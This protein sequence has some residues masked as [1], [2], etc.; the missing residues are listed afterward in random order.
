MVDIE[1]AKKEFLKYTEKFDLKNEHIKGKQQHSLRVMQVSK[2]I[3]ERLNLNKEDVELATLIGL[4]HDIARFEQY[5]IYNTFRDRDSIDHGNYGV[6]I[7]E[8]DIRK[9]I[10]VDE[11]DEIIKKAVKNHNKYRIEEVLNIEE[12]V[13]AKI[14]R[15]AD[16]IDIIY[17]AVDS[18]WKDDKEVLEI[19]N[20]KLSEKM[21]EDFYSYRL[22][23]ILNSVSRTD[24][25]LKYSSFV[26]DI[27]FKG[28]L[29]ILK[30]NDNLNKM[31]N[32][33]N[34][35]IPETR[36]EMNRIKQFVNDYIKEKTK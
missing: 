15:D 14:V 25:I 13:F 19:E 5:T 24:H 32:R 35:Q 11:Y 26:F 29:E 8:K 30:E 31:I 2:E 9:Y 10:D 33:F 36:E 12:E 28:S 7:L 6:Q 18:F 21:L 34:Y 4:L 1:L 17:E 27:Y 22:S 20:G 3:A 23:N 16:K